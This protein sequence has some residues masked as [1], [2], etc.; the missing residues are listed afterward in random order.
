M[1]CPP[2]TVTARASAAATACGQREF[3]AHGPVRKIR[4]VKDIQTGEP[5]G[6]AFVEYER[7]KDMKGAWTRP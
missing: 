1:A 6:Y 5:R 4:L 2:L 3:E 7:E